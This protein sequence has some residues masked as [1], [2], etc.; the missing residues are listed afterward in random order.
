MHIVT[1]R[2]NEAKDLVLY[3][4]E[5]SSKHKRTCSASICELSSRENPFASSSP[6]S[7]AH[8]SH[9][10][11]TNGA[12]SPRAPEI[13]SPGAP[14]ITSPG[15]H[16]ITCPINSPTAKEATSPSAESPVWPQA[17]RTPV[18]SRSAPRLSAQGVPRRGEQQMQQIGRTPVRQCSTSS[19]SVSLG[20]QLARPDG[21]RKEDEATR[22]Q[23]Y[24]AALENS[25]G[26]LCT[27]FLGT[28]VQGRSQREGGKSPLPRNRKNC[29]RK[30]ILFPKALILVTHFPK[31]V[32]FFY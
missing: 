26:I 14:E 23:H 7:G 12:N 31:I 5:R 30:M 15:A 8:S 25:D 1:A 27:L 32:R 13:T 28:S 10:P 4:G 18:R 17:S 20:G 24:G 3:T 29:C 19:T 11:C 16:E 2:K 22:F 9:S 6:P 21:A